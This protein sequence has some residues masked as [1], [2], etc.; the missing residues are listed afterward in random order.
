M[1]NYEILKTVKEYCTALLLLRLEKDLYFHNL[2]HTVE[3]VNA[4][5][6]IGTESGLSPEEINILCIAAWFHDTGYCNTYKN[7]EAESINIASVF[8][9]LLN[10]EETILEKI[11][12]CILATKVPQQPQTIL[13]KIICD[14]DFYHFSRTD[15]PEHEQ[16]LK[17]EWE[18]HC[19][20]FYTEEEWNKG[21][22]KM[23]KDHSYFTFYGQQVLQLRKEENI[24]RLEQVA[25]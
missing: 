14:A 24:K 1:N 20:L 22:Y 21:N 15:Y 10:I 17:K 7:H 18:I 19:Q 11:T 16:A 2:S 3:V 13:E 25:K 23:L 5:F 6:E 9:K 8:L 4:C 12:G